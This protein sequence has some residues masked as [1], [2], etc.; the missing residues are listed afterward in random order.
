M[1]DERLVLGDMEQL[2]QVR[3]RRP[4]VDVW[5]AIVAKDS[6]APVEVQIDRRRLQIGRVVWRDTNAARLEFGPDV[7]I[8]QDAH[9]GESS[10]MSRCSYRVSTSRLRSSRSSKLWYTLANRM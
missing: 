1:Q 5:I 6:K 2:G 10:G 4:D 3:L 8:C 9:P 7:A